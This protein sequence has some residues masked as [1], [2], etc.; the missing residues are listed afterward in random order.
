VLLRHFI[1]V[2]RCGFALLA[3]SVLLLAGC[4]TGIGD[5]KGG[6]RIERSDV[7]SKALTF[8]RNSCCL[9]PTMPGRTST[10]R[11]S[12]PSAVMTRLRN[13]AWPMR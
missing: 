13:K 1:N 9:T 2:S 6:M 7:P 8:S 12:L 4:A 11:S 3:L 10:W 5:S